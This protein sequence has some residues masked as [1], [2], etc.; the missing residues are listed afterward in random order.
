MEIETTSKLLSSISRS[1]CFKATGKLKCINSDSTILTSNRKAGF[2]FSQQLIPLLLS[3]A[4]ITTTYPPTLIFTGATASVKASANF[5]SF[6]SAKFGLRALSQ[7]LAREFGPQGVHI[8]H[9]IADGVFD[10]E[11][12]RSYGGMKEGLIDTDGIAEAYWNLHTQGKRAWTW[13]IDLR[14]YLVCVSKGI[15]LMIRKT[16]RQYMRK[17]LNLN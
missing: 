9:V 6:G 13:E 2:I 16:G 11:R 7:S 15:E 17:G 4:S 8:S 12:G 5:V 3:T 10:S 14:S 1:P